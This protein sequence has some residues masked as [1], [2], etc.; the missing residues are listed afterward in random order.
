[1]RTIILKRLLD[2]NLILTDLEPS[3]TCTIFF[4]N[5]I[6]IWHWPSKQFVYYYEW[7]LCLGWEPRT[8]IAVGNVVCA[9]KKY[10]NS[11]VQLDVF[12][13]K[14]QLENRNWIWVEKLMLEY[15]YNHW[16]IQ[17]QTFTN[18]KPYYFVIDV[19]WV[20][21]LYTAIT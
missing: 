12:C 1:M 9:T 14:S 17:N 21:S 6:N 4:V 8:I 16:R 13:L 3:I 11:L 15:K 7:K 18:L 20:T 5:I 2:S 10:S 19:D